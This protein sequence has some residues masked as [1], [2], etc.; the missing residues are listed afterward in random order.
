MNGTARWQNFQMVPCH[1]KCTEVRCG[2]MSS[3][4]VVASSLA[5]VLQARGEYSAFCFGEYSA[6]SGIL[7]AVLVSIAIW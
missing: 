4:Q 3:K 5:L 7:Q 1:H 6:M 2:L